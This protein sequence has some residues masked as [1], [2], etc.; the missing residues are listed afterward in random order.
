MKVYEL[1]KPHVQPLN[2]SAPD[3][4]IYQKPFKLLIHHNNF[5]QSHTTPKNSSYL[6]LH[7]PTV[8]NNAYL[9]FSEVQY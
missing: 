8:I 7:Y 6:T 2:V 1:S 9:P 5:N 3:A 4:Y